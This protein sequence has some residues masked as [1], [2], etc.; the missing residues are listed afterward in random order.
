[1]SKADEIRFIVQ[2]TGGNS[3]VDK[4][5]VINP[6]K[7]IYYNKWIPSSAGEY[8]LK[9]K[10]Y[11]SG[12]YVKMTSAK[13]N[14]TAQKMNF[15]AM[16]VDGSNDQIEAISVY[17]NPNSGIVNINFGSLTNAVLKVYSASGQIVYQQNGLSG[18]YQFELKST[19]GLYFVEVDSETEKQIFKV[20]K[21]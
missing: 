20:V 7:P 4:T 2:K 14:V 19:P 21:N 10:A 13:I 15:R 3:K 17:P 12:K 1:M 9:V 8:R 18:L 16:T 11:K 5:E 6:S